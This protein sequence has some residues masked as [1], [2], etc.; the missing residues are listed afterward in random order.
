MGGG[1]G[2]TE[3]GRVGAGKV[4]K[5]P[6]VDVDEANAGNPCDASVGVGVGVGVPVYG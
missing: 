6:A 3:D 1:P 2:Y 5:L 4:L